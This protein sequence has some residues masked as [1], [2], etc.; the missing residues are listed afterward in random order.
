MAN[1]ELFI[2]TEEGAEPKLIKIAS[3]ATVAELVKEIQAAGGV[4][5]ERGEEII[6]RVEEKDIVCRKEHK[7]HDHG[8]KHGHHLRCHHHEVIIFVN[9][10]EKKWEK[11]EISFDEAVILAYGSIS[12]D[13]KVSYT[14]MY[15]KGPQPKPSG[16]LVKGKSVKVKN[17]MIFDVS[18]TG[19]S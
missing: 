16:S 15:S 1:I 10:R 17:G 11:K 7:L 13:P 14:V 4:H 12:T 9:T 6:L 5:C 18:Q 2:H 3:D 8:I 19:Q